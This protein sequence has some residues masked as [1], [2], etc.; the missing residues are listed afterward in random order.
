MKFSKTIDLHACGDVKTL[1][2]EIENYVNYMLEII[3]ANDANTQKKLRT[4][5][6]A[7]DMLI[8]SGD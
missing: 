4:L 1:A 8:D 7:V 3:E 5:Q 6:A 2:A